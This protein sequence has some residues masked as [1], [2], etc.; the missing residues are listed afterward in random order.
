[1]ILAERVKFLEERLG[2][3]IE[4]GII[5]GAAFGLVTPSDATFGFRGNAQIVPD[6]EEIKNDSIFDVASLTKVV[7]TLPSI[8]ILQENGEIRLDNTVKYFLPDF[9]HENTTILQLLTHA[10]GLPG[11]VK[12]YKTC[13]NKNEIIT[14]LKNTEI[15][16][17]PGT[18]AIAR[19]GA[20]RDGI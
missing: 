20:G 16:Y 3:Y 6:V 11:M 2:E 18:R 15:E 7:A 14:T 1:M 12:F 4:E 19:P 13:R 10:S 5:P 17:E 8:L 9:S